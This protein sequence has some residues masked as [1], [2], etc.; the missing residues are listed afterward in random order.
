MVGGVWKE[1]KTCKVDGTK[2]P[3]GYAAHLREVDWLAG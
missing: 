2:Y 3:V 1:N